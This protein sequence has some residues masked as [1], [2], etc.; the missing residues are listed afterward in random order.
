LSDRLVGFNAHL[1]MSY[2]LETLDFD[3][4]GPFTFV[5]QVSTLAVAE[6]GSPWPTAL[7]IFHSNAYTRDDRYYAPAGNNVLLGCDGHYVVNVFGNR[8]W[9]GRLYGKLYNGPIVRNPRYEDP[10]CGDGG[11]GGWDPW[12]DPIHMTGT[13]AFPDSVDDGMTSGC[14][15]SD[16]ASGA[17]S[18]NYSCVWDYVTLEISYDGGRTWQHFWSGWLQVCDEN[19]A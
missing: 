14:G 6:G 19:M 9:V 3:F 16:G 10:E 15:G 12:D 2:G 13:G 18:G 7:Y 11:G 4:R 1:R 17:G 5:R 8:L